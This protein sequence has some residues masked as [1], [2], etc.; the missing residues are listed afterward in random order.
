LQ[1]YTDR[2]GYKRGVKSAG[3]LMDPPVIDCSGWASLLLTRAM[4]AENEA[5]DYV[6]TRSHDQDQNLSG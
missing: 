2:A 6:I 5:A 3:L 1:L 4:Q